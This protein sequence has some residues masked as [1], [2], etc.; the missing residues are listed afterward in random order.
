LK[1]NA[2]SYITSSSALDPMT[3]AAA[4]YA[5]VH[6]KLCFAFKLLHGLLKPPLANIAPWAAM[7]TQKV[8]P[9]CSMCSMLMCGDMIIHAWNSNA[10]RELAEQAPL[11]LWHSP[12]HITNHFYADCRLRSRH[13]SQGTGSQTC[14]NWW[15]CFQMW[16]CLE[17]HGVLSLQHPQFR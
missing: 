14:R 6:V 17:Q 13:G 7:A 2:S 3:S 9:W 4:A 15:N 12:D 1:H 5:P 11:A 16:N 10:P 8:R